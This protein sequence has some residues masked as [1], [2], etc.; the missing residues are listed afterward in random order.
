MSEKTLGAG[1][2]G[3]AIPESAETEVSPTT[4]YLEYALHHIQCAL[5]KADDAPCSAA[6]H[7][8]SAKLALQLGRVPTPHESLDWASEAPRDPE[9]WPC[10]FSYHEHPT[11]AEAVDCA[12]QRLVGSHGNSSLSEASGSAQSAAPSSAANEKG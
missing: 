8:R 3:Q 4:G 7:E 12:R 6:Q 5:A 1:L 2:I 9:R 11:R 10:S